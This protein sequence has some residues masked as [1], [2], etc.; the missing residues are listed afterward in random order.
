MRV[1]ARG[2][3][4]V[5]AA[6]GPR[7]RAVR[8][9]SCSVSIKTANIEPLSLLSTLRRMAPMVWSGEVAKGGADVGSGGG[10]NHW[11]NHVMLD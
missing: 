4:A 6:S 7:W 5:V 2:P 10:K 8:I 3:M 9:A 11:A 1:V